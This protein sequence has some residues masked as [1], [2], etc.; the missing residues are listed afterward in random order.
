MTRKLLTVGLLASVLGV[1]TALPVNAAL[2]VTEGTV[3]GL[4]DDNVISNACTGGID[5]PAT[6]IKGCLNS[7]HNQL[8]N[9]LAEENILYSAGGQA[10]IESDDGNGFSSLTVSVAGKT[11][12]SLLLNIGASDDG[13]V[14]FSSS[15]GDISIFYDISKNGNNKFTLTGGP[16]DS[17][18]IKT[19]NSAMTME[20]DN[21][22]EDKQFRIGVVNP[23]VP[24]P[25]PE[26]ASLALFGSGLVGL[27]LLRRFRRRNR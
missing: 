9:F 16:W 21:Q 11:F 23:T 2:I 1:A 5:G 26:P 8:V 24:I 14:Q 4:V 6:L 27:G 20:V 3:G 7:D 19:Y 18:T 12:Q 17:I 13:K 10:V 22:D 25:T 15:E